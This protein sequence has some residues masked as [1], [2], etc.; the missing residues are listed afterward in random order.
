M[1][2]ISGPTKLVFALLLSGGSAGFASTIAVDAYAG[3]VRSHEISDEASWAL[4]RMNTTLREKQFSFRTHTI[5]SYA[6]PNGELLHI[7]HDMKTIF[8]RPDRLAVD[9]NGD[10]GAIKLRYGGQSVVLFA[11][12][13]KKYSSVPVAGSIDAA[14]DTIEELSGVDFPVADLLSDDPA[15]SVLS[16]VTAGSQVGVS[17]IDGVPCRH[18]FFSQAPDAEFELWLEDN[19]RSLPRRFVVTYSLLPGRPILIAELSDWDFSTQVSDGVFEFEPPAGV[20]KVELT[21]KRA[22]GEHSN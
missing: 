10:D 4:A 8:R 18:F 12:D 2:R 17:T 6:G 19:E 5:R 20:N 11:I 7:V 1:F 15:E 14:L 21:P 13:Q 3:G 9:V 22:S 16:G